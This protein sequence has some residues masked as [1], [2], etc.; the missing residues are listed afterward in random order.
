MQWLHLLKEIFSGRRFSIV[1]HRQIIVVAVHPQGKPQVA[2][3][4]EV[5]EAFR[6]L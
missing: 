5:T 1:S 6:S 2:W 3:I 4:K